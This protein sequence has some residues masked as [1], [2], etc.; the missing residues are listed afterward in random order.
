MQ[1]Q[2]ASNGVF[3]S[4]WAHGLLW[5]VYVLI[6]LSFL[7]TRPLVGLTLVFLAVW[8]AGKAPN[9]NL[10]EKFIA[11]LK[12]WRSEKVRIGIT[13]LTLF[14]ALIFSIPTDGVPQSND[15][16]PES[17]SEEAVVDDEVYVTEAGTL[18]RTIEEKV[19]QV[20]GD[21]TNMGEDT[22][23]DV[24][25]VENDD[26]SSTLWIDYVAGSNL[27]NRLTRRGV[28][29]DTEDLIQQLPILLGNEIASITVR[30]HLMLVDTYGNEDMGQVMLIEISRETWER[31]N[32]SNFITDDIPVVADIYWV[33]PAIQD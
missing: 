14:I 27:S 21:D 17:N 13:I 29:M 15:S 6:A 1:S 22:V 4:K 3:A 12:T 20:L 16:T 11:N 28:W 33:H 25:F 9:G 8:S 24:R 10:W 7:V 19:D 31:I 18:E 23:I 32:W 30:A 5:A 2:K 26:G